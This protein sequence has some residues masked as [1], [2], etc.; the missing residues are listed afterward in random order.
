MV[1]CWDEGQKE[2]TKV[3]NKQHNR[4]QNK[5]KTQTREGESQELLNGG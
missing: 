5:I 4:K 2:A 3:E 1:L